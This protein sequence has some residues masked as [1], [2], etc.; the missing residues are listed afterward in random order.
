MKSSLESTPAIRRLQIE[1][2]VTLKRKTQWVKRYAKIV[3]CV[4]TYKKQKTDRA[5]KAR[6][7]LRNA[8]IMLGQRD[9]ASN[10]APYIYIQENPLKPEAV[11]ISFEDEGTL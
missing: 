11:R 8:K 4:F 7:D 6:I 10:L 3:D 9:P 2:M 1:G 5:D